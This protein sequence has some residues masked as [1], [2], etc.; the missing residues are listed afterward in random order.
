MTM[1]IARKS[2]LTTSTSGIKMVPTMTKHLRANLSCST[3]VLHPLSCIA[4]T[5]VLMAHGAAAQ[6][7][8]N[9]PAFDVAT[10]KPVQTGALVSRM[11]L[12]N[13]PNGIDA[14]YMTVPWLIRIAYGSTKLL[15]DDQVIGAPDWAKSE[16]YNILAKMSE[17]DAA[18]F[19]KLSPV[20]KESNES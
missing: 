5:I 15:L 20:S 3:N 8:S 16:R 12:W 2:S 18:A 10:I 14:A 17:D 4:A 11:G 9:A 6:D 13:T 7:A 1:H 19:Q